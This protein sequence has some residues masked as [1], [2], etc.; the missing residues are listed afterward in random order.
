MKFRFL[1]LLITSIGVIPAAGQYDVSFT[2][3]GEYSQNQFETL[4]INQF[5]NT[6]NDF[7]GSKLGSPYTEFTGKELTH[8]NVGAGVRFST[9][10][11][12]GFTASTSFLYG[13]VSYAKQA[14]WS[15][16]VKNELAFKAKD[17]MWAVTS[18][19]HFWRKIYL[20]VYFDANG[21][22]LDMEHA[23]IYPDGSRSL[24]SE[25]KLNGFYSALIASSDI[26]IQAGLKLGRFLLYFKP[27]WA[28]KN[29]PPAKGLVALTDYTTVNYPPNDFPAD[30]V[31]YA[32][33]P[34]EFVT[35]DLGVKSDDFE[36]FRLAFGFE[37]LL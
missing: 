1:L 26:G 28:M 24:S 32:T 10:E 4:R 27:S 11:K 5:V 36:G 8:P 2:L 35:Q 13:Q 18:G 14:T 31:T 25:Y 21:R 12:V 6:F 7:W 20:E 16:G 9:G 34:V 23:T 15:T 3:I 22:F 33:D 37:I 30:F 29:F 19:V 17:A